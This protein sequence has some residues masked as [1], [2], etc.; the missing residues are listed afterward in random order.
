MTPIITSTPMN[1]ARMVSVDLLPMG[2]TATPNTGP[3]AMFGTGSCTPATAYSGSICIN[4]ATTETIC[5]NA[6]AFG[7]SI[8]ADCLQHLHGATAQHRGPGHYPC[9]R[10]LCQ[11]DEHHNRRLNVGSLDPL[12]LHQEG[13]QLHTA[14]SIHATSPHRYGSDRHSDNLCQCHVSQLSAEQHHLQSLRFGETWRSRVQL[15]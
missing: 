13:Q 7:N 11:S 1:W 2:V 12:L 6:T 5:A 10:Y 15:R 14:P 3:T 9:F 4:P 8:S